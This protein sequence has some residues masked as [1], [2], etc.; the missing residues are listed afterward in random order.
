MNVAIGIA[1]AGILLYLLVRGYG[2]AKL[3]QGG[4]LVRE[5]THEENAKARTR[6]DTAASRPLSLD[7]G[8]LAA[9]WRA[10]RRRRELQE[11]TDD[12]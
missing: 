8:K 7:L 12:A 6:F 1:A 3:D 2:K 4:S 5:K 9:R 11:P 10:R